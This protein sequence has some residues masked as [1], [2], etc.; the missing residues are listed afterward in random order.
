MNMINELRE[1]Y[2]LKKAIVGAKEF[3][4]NSQTSVPS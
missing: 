2:F 1:D 4:E 3:M